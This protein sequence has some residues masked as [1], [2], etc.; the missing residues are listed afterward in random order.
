VEGDWSGAAF[1][2]VAGVIAGEMVVTGLDVFS[3]QA[4]RAIL[5]PLMQT[6]A[7]LSIEEKQVT[8]RPG[9]LQP[10]HFNATDCPDLFPPLAALAAY[11]NGTSVIEGVHR[12]IFKESD[13]ASVLQMELGKL[14]VEVIIQDD[15]MVIKGGQP[16]KAGNVNSHGDHRI[17]MALGVLAL[18]AEG[19]VIIENAEVIH[20]SY[21]GFYKD[22]ELLGAAISLV[23][24]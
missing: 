6:G 14:G 4:D 1:L 5:Q 12:L 11:C 24:N 3:S 19:E 17:A 15:L 2:L 7:G 18:K 13:R 10:F 22:L 16:V 8:A 20:K 21:P 23:N 9:N